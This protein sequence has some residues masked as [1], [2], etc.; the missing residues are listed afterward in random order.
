MVP[1]E[2]GSDRLM[3]IETDRAMRVVPWV[4]PD[5]DTIS[6]VV[7]APEWTS[8]PESSTRY[9]TD[10]PPCCPWRGGQ[11]SAPLQRTSR[12]GGSAAAAE[13]QGGQ[14]CSLSA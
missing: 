7:H 2:R 3:T 11:R 4:N 13:W 6:S 8:R 5:L 14:C 9:L 10:R 1:G 12:S